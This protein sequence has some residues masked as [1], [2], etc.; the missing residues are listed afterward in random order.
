MRTWRFSRGLS[1]VMIL[2]FLLVLVLSGCGTT[3]GTSAKSGSSGL[4]IKVG[5]I[6]T[7]T[8]P[9]TAYTQDA[10]DG[11]KLA[12]N[13]IAKEGGPKIEYVT[14]DDQYKV[15]QALSWAK[16]LV[17]NEKVDVLAGTINSAV[18]LAV[19][20]YA[21][22]NKIPFINWGA[23]SDEITGAK[24]HRYVFSTP[25][26]TAMIAKTG[27]IQ[28]SQLPYTKFWLA[29]SDYE[30]GHLV[31]SDFWT[32]LQKLK[33]GVQKLGE[34]WWKIGEPDF[35]PYLTAIRAAKPDAVIV[36]AGAADI[37]PFMKALK[38]TGLSKQIP[39]WI[40]QSIDAGTLRALGNDQ[41]EGVLGTN[42]YF[43]YY[44]D[45]AANKQFEQEFKQATNREPGFAG[46]YGY[47]AGKY[48]GAAIQKAGSTDREKIVDAL[49]GLTLDTPVGQLTMRKED[50]QSL[51]P[52]FYGKTP[53]TGVVANGLVQL[54]PD[55]VMPS[56]EDVMNARAKK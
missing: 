17:M 33:P 31:V 18:S 39:V 51:D 43:Y 20:Q 14:R 8:G 42:Q 52:L 37:I 22:Q 48:L 55:K 28:I 12:V 45:T 13:D 24:G 1:F 6:D 32:D 47:M 30:Y 40:P 10:L 34:T 21:K 23:L 5:I 27:A 2:V 50:H 41:P 35:T 29:G 54:S 36:G 19:S 16:E 46:L 44:P 53:G 25:P 7:Y 56:V 49:E 15:D 11:F 4:T 26:N 9:P 38:A 3:G